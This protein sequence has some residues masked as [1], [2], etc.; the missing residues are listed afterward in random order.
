MLLVGD[1]DFFGIFR[2]G[3]WVRGFY[4]GRS[5]LEVRV[6]WYRL[7]LGFGRDVSY[8][9]SVLVIFKKLGV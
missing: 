8:S 2:V 7:R 3:G 4:E 9:N 1:V 6:K 5:F